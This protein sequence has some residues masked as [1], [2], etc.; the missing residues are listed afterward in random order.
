MK[1]NFIISLVISTLTCKASAECFAN[2]LGYSCC[3]KTKE[4]LSIDYNGK[5]GIE[6]GKKCGIEPNMNPIEVKR[7]LN[8]NTLQKRKNNKNKNK[9]KEIENICPVEM[10]SRKEGV[11]YPLYYTVQYYSQ[12]T[13]SER[14]LNVVLPVGYNTSKKYPVLYYLHG[15]MG[16]ENTML[17]EPLGTIAIYQNLLQEKRTKEMIIVVPSQYAPAPGTEV[18]PSLTQPFYDGYDNFI[19]DLVNDIM[20][21]ME[22]NYS[23]AT[24]RENTAICGFSFGGRNSLYIGYVRSDL[25]GYV[26]AFS[27]APG[28]TEAQDMFSFHKGLLQPEQLVAENP[29]IVTMLSCGTNDTVVGTFPKEYHEILEQNNQKHIWYEIP[30][31]DHDL[32][33]ITTSYYNFMDSVFGILDETKPNI[34]PFSGYSDESESSESSGEESESSNPKKNGKNKKGNMKKWKNYM[35]KME[36]EIVNYL[37]QG[38]DTRYDNVN[39]PKVFKT[40]YY[41]KTTDTQRKVDIVLPVNY[42]KNKKYPVLYY[43]HGIFVEPDYMLQEELGTISIYGNLVYQKLAKDMIIVIPDQY[44]APKGQEVEQGLNQDYYDGY[45]NFINDLV[46]D[47]MPFIANN[48]SIRTGRENTAI[49]GFSFGGRNSL[50]IGYVRSDLFGYVGALSPAPGVT[51]GEDEWSVHKCLLSE[52]ELVAKIPPIVTFISGGT[53]DPAVGTFPKQYSDILTRNG[54]KHVYL[55]IPGGEHDAFSNKVGYYNFI[56]SIFGILKDDD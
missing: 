32:T 42:K 53:N 21:Y 36:M 41:S 14:P 15:I 28:I 11:E 56:K 16:D 3:T 43:L 52:N 37:P 24:G 35:D 29:P 27:P 33:A 5:W 45:D 34:A 39:Y 22:E 48:F 44:A 26:G 4:V 55:S 51:P 49:C 38:I 10:I 23:I 46:N 30:D 8:N 2:K 40:S 13:Q 50:Y 17:E 9:D 20:P 6:N 18:P 25:F 31:A 19:N 7:N 47:L 12:T 1:I 54:Q